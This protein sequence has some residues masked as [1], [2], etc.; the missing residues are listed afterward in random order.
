MHQGISSDSKAT[1]KLTSEGR[2]KKK[3]SHHCFIEAD[4]NLF[5]SHC[6][7]RERES[8][9]QIATDRS[10]GTSLL[11]NAP[12][13]VMGMTDCIGRLQLSVCV[14]QLTMLMHSLL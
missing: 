10:G 5:S 8:E 14:K 13:G 2:E 11:P 4:K 12:A 1:L 6:T 9:S 3:K 7:E